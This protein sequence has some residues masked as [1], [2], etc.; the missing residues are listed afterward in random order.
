MP[1]AIAN[2]LADHNERGQVACLGEIE[3]GEDVAPAQIE[4]LASAGLPLRRRHEWRGCFDSLVE[5]M[6]PVSSLPRGHPLRISCHGENFL[7]VLESSK[8]GVC[9]LDR[10]NVERVRGRRRRV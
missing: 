4:R 7:W 8:R 5:C 6:V 9:K 2:I 3:S 10:F 1:R